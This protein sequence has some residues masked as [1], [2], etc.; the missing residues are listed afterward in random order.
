MTLSSSP[1][2]RPQQTLTL[3]LQRPPWR[4]LSLS[5]AEVEVTALRVGDEAVGQQLTHDMAVGRYLFC[6]G[7]ERR[8]ESG[9]DAC[10]A[11][12]LVRTQVARVGLGS[13]SACSIQWDSP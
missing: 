4:T 10:N 6:W 5:D 13:W 12:R 11:S 8:S 3:L 1:T 2:Q 7:F 9:T